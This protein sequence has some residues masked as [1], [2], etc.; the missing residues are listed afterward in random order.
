[1][2]TINKPRTLGMVNPI[3]IT[4]RRPKLSWY[5]TSDRNDTLQ[6]ACQVIISDAPETV[7]EGK[8]SWYDSGKTDSDEPRLVVPRLLQESGKRL[9]WAVRAW[10]NHGEVSEWS[11]PQFFETGFFRSSDWKAVWAE[12]VQ[13]SAPVLDGST[14]PFTESP[15]LYM[16]VPESELNPS[17]LLRKEFKA[18]KTVKKARLYATA[19]GVY[20]AFINGARVGDLEMMPE[21]TPYKKMLQV[22]TYDVTDMIRTGVNAVGAELGNGWWAGTVS[23]YAN[24]A[25]YGDTLALL[26]QLN[27]EYADGSCE[28]IGTDETWMCA[29][30]A[31]VYSDLGIGE[32]ID[33]RK[34][35]AHWNEPGMEITG[36]WRAAQLKDYG[37]ENLCGQNTSPARVIRTLKPVSAKGYE[38]GTVIVDFGQIISG[39]ARIIFDGTGRA[40]DEIILSYCEQVDQ[41]GDFVNNFAGYRQH[42]D[43]LIL[44]GKT[45]EIYEPKFSWRGFRWLRIMGY[46]GQP[47]LSKM[48]ARLI[49]SDLEKISTFECSDPRVTKLAE[50]IQWTLINNL[51]SIPTD[52]P[53]RERGG[54]TG[55]FEMIA[56]TMHYNYDLEEFLNRWMLEHR[57]E[58]NEDG[59]IPLIIPNHMKRE[60]PKMSAGWGDDCVIVPWETYRTYGDPAILA[61]NYEMMQKWMAFVKNRCEIE[62]CTYEKYRKVN[63]MWNMDMK[64]FTDYGQNMT[65]E[66]MERFS[67]LWDGDYQFGDWMVPSGNVKEDGSWSYISKHNCETF[68]PCYYLAYTTQLMAEIAG[69]LGK[70]ADASYYKNWNQKVREA[71]IAELYDNGYLPE[72]RFQGVLTM[73]L[74]AGLYPEGSR[75]V[76]EDRLIDVIYNKDDGKINTGFT[77]MEHIMEILVKSG[78]PETAYDLLLNE[79]TPSFLYMIDH[80]ATAIWETWVNID[81]AGTVNTA[82]YT[83][84]AIGNVGRW[85]MSGIAGISPAEPGYKK[86]RIAP[87]PDPKGRISGASAS[88]ETKYGPIA[89][90][91]QDDGKD[92]SLEVQV[93]VG[94]EAEIVLPGNEE[95]RTVGSGKYTFRSPK[96]ADR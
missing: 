48:E 49:A 4:V 93:P 28:I 62:P 27:I 24:S 71:V 91:W 21:A 5:L 59:R 43:R 58:Q 9:Y 64:I 17:L 19:H 13:K 41:N 26:M 75:K 55:D 46:S 73:A 53:D 84:Y 2:L 78:H 65:P 81:D 67:Y 89:V 76:L 80:G 79:R 61:D 68:T 16:E 35:I 34:L 32:K 11:E 14:I 6:T 47:D 12:P 8:G 70:R 31:I 39:N 96:I 22:Q 88:Y 36:Q 54:W 44:S 29:E 7:R 74:K 82:S 15:A 60:L 50:N 90:N 37:Y 33:C 66:R 72:S 42:E 20:Q 56:A 3:G 85:L 92:V 10:D 51:L 63:R 52:N 69:I 45:E 1:M 57:L 40:G 38:D 30:G 94:T 23:V 86:I 18:E 25:L 95:I 87:V 77:S 83:Q